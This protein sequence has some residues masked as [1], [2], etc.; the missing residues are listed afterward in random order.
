MS[1]GPLYPVNLR[2]AGRR[3]LVV[4]GGGVARGKVAGLVDAE[5]AVEVVAPT[6]DDAIRSM[7][8]TCTERA[9]EPGDLEGRWLVVTATDDPEVNAR[10]RADAD[11]AGIWVNSA[12][13]PENCTFTLPARVRRGDLLVTIST[14]GRSPA[15]SSWVR[16]WIESELGPEHEQLL[17]VLSEVREELRSQGTPTEGLD[18]QG[19]VDSGTLDLIR[20]GHLDQAKERLQACLSSSSD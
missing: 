20:Q 4:G 9:Y 10:V 19:A 7:G 17:E 18:W 13:D 15:M 8:V 3:A 11:A 1:L 2:M 12:D 5:A 6:I 14:G 16:R